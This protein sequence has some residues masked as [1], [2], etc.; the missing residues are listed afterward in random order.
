LRKQPPEDWFG[1]SSLEATDNLRR[2]HQ[3]EIERV[4]RGLNR[5]ERALGGLEQNARG[6]AQADRQRLADQFDSALQGLQQGA[7]K[8]NQALMDQ[9]GKLDPGMLDQ[10][11]P[12]QLEQLR[13]ALRRHAQG[14][15]QCQGGD[16]GDDDWLDE[17]L[18]E[19]NPDDRDGKGPG[20]GGVNRG[21]GTSTDVFGPEHGDLDIGELTPLEAKDLSRSAPGDLLQLQDGE[22]QVDQTQRGP[23]AGG[24]V[25]GSGTGG[26]R[27]WRE[28]LDPEEQRAI[29]RFFE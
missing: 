28:A 1:H 10:L 26:E 11:D 23:T 8:P 18:G 27:I 25:D 16:C 3:S 12:Q 24:T 5:A 7:L 19:E 4:E 21:P 13:D 6:M 20:R 15:G 29:K 22:H 9:L 17:L 2:D 14:F